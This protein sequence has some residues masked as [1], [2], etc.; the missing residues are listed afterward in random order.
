MLKRIGLLLMF[1]LVLLP[2]IPVKAQAVFDVAAVIGAGVSDGDLYVYTPDESI[3]L[4]EDGLGG[5]RQIEWQ[6]DVLAYSRSDADGVLNLWLSIDGEAPFVLL[7]GIDSSVPLQ[8]YRRRTD[9]L[10]ARLPA[11]NGGLLPDQCLDPCAGSG[12]AAA[13]PGADRHDHRRVAR[14]RWRLA[15]P[16][17]LAVL[18]RSRFRGQTSYPGADALRS[19]LYARLCGRTH[20]AAEPGHAGNN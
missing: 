1:C 2:V 16:D 20:C 19:G 7:N 11:R 8:F 13:S 14:L 15:Y 4:T 6:G 9:S 18:G 10:R 3:K 12:R 5:F 17:R